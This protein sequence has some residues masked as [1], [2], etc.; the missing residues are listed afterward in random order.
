MRKFI[1]IALA[2]CC[3]FPFAPAA[4]RTQAKRSANAAYI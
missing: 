1:A 4:T 3:V 2:F